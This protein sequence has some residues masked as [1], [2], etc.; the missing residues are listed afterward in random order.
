MKTNKLVIDTS[1][2][3]KWFVTDDELYTKE[4]EQI[5]K[6]AVA[7][8][9]VLYTPSLARYELG[10]SI[11]KRKTNLLS[12]FDYLETFYKSPITIVDETEELAL[13]TYRIAH[14]YTLTYYDASFVALAKQENAILITDNTKHQAKVKEAKVVPLKDYK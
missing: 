10:N 13:L 7:N 12:A 6:D 3:V 5:L 8:K 4:A 11:V 9:I 14:E 2:I 1:V